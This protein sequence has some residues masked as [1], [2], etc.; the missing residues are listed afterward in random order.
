MRLKN[1]LILK[2]HKLG[3]YGSQGISI[4]DL[5]TGIKGDYSSQEY[6]DAIINLFKRGLIIITNSSG[7]PGIS[8]NPKKK[9][10]IDKLIK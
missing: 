1:I 8:L 6:E 7:Y 9:R 5:K 10:E 4:D 3:I 2:L